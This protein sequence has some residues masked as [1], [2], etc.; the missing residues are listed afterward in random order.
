MDGIAVA[1][2]HHP[3]R[4]QVTRLN[5]RGWQV[6]LDGLSVSVP[7]Q[8]SAEAQ[9]DDLAGLLNAAYR[10]LGI[11]VLPRTQSLFGLRA[12][13]PEVLSA[14]VV[15]I[16][17]AAQRIAEQSWNRR[18]FDVYACTSQAWQDAGAPVPYTLLLDTLRAALPPDRAS[19]TEYNDTS[20]DL[21]MQ[22]LYD[23]AISMWHGATD[24]RRS[25]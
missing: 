17:R 9:L 7:A 13:L 10:M 21:A 5:W 3:K 4:G 16:L 12:T 6:D 25:A 11:A 2:V 15:T 19:L 18:S 24:H 23:Q 1:T 20:G 22:T 14:D 8:H